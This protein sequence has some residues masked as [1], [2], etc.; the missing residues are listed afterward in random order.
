MKEALRRPFQGSVLT[1]GKQELLMSP[2]QL[3]HYAKKAGLP[4]NIPRYSDPYAPMVDKDFFSLLGFSEVHSLDYSEFEGASVIF[5]LNSGQTPEKYKEAFDVI[6]DGGTME[7][8][9][10]L[11]NAL[12][13]VIWMLKP[14]GRIIH[15]CPASNHLEHSFYMF[16]P[17]FF[18]DFYKTN[19]FDINSIQIV[20]C[21]PCFDYEWVTYDYHS[22]C[23]AHT[24]VGMGRLDKG[25]Y[26][27]H[28][29][30]TKTEC[31][32][33]SA[34]PNQSIYSSALWDLPKVTSKR[35]WLARRFKP[36]TLRKWK[37]IFKRSPVYPLW[38]YCKLKARKHG[39]PLKVADKF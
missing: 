36:E 7:H 15:L 8:I 18:S 10:H 33:S 38:A 35:S 32:T 29:V 19:Q 20:R 5:D 12:K 25:M 26:L 16:S 27:V 37:Q 2:Y 23:M 6:Y 21:T 14:G 22:L 13:S 1:L 31:S 3:K 11:P 24:D 34:I 9:F 30:V 39:I 4:L 17:T 28:T